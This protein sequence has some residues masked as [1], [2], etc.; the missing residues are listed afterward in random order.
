MKEINY[1]ERTMPSG[2][3]CT[4]AGIKWPTFL[5]GK[6][7]N[8]KVE[9]YVVTKEI[10]EGGKKYYVI[11]NY[12]G[13]F[14]VEHHEV[15][16]DFNKEPKLLE[17][18]ECEWDI[19]IDP[20]LREKARREKVVKLAAK[21]KDPLVNACQKLVKYHENVQTPEAKAKLEELKRI[22]NAD[23]DGYID[24]PPLYIRGAE[25]SSKQK[26]DLNIDLCGDL[27][28][29]AGLD[30]KTPINLVQKKIKRMGK[31]MKQLNKDWQELHE[32]VP[33]LIDLYVDKK[34]RMCR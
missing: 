17:L 22:A 21:S 8:E 5:N 14:K 13:T 25:S 2:T 9:R 34:R 3:M 30:D 27:L 33:K 20:Q 26:L 11:K 7:L 23:E 19:V 18:G 31:L 12:R 1:K 28:K 16:L 32:A 10:Q 6:C 4:L 15:I 29:L 24:E